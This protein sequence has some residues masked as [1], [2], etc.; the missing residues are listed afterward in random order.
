MPEVGVRRRMRGLGGGEEGG[1]VDR[2]QVAAGKAMRPHPPAT[3]DN[4]SGAAWQN[5][6]WSNGS[7]LKFTSLPSP[8]SIARSS[9]S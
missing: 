3:G 7:N 8:A 4:A 2:P 6:S 5:D 1:L 9:A